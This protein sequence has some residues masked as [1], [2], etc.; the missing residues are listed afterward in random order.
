MAQTVK[1]TLSSPERVIESSCILMRSTLPFISRFSHPCIFQ[2]QA[3]LSMQKI[4]VCSFI[5]QSYQQERG[6]APGPSDLD[7]A[8]T[9]PYQAGPGAATLPSSSWEQ[10]TLHLPQG[11]HGSTEQGCDHESLNPPV[12]QS[13]EGMLNQ[14]LISVSTV[15]LFSQLR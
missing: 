15:S 2:M 7:Q 8:G 1:N 4:P 9:G 11:V 14:D 10:F 12:I 5:P 6:A 13:A 3:W